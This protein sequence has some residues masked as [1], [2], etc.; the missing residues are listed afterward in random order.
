M[1]DEARL[2]SDLAISNARVFDGDVIHDGRLSVGVTAN[3]VTFVG[4]SPPRAAKM[5]EAGGKFLMPGLIDCHLH[6]LNMWTA[7]DE[8]TMA[9]DIN[10]ELKTRLHAL[11]DAGV[12]TVK[13]VGDSED[14]ILRVR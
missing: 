2:A 9:V 11:L 3:K 10:G 6:L 5:I 7:T 13:S 12:T 8:A 14:D 1:P 4:P